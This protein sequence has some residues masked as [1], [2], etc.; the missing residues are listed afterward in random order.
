MGIVVD[1]N[2]LSLVFDQRNSRHNEFRPVLR[3]IQCGKDR[4]VYGGST[5]KA[6]LERA[7][8]FLRIIIELRNKRKARQLDTNDVDSKE[9][10]LKDIIGDSHFN[11]HHIIAIVIVGKCKFVCSLDR[12]LHV[13]LQDRSLYPRHCR[14]PGIYSGRACA[15]MLHV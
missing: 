2:T 15:H 12:A 6:E 1:I 5:Y 11:D 13:L 14:R 10:R 7:R 4:L 9:A 3:W 8:K